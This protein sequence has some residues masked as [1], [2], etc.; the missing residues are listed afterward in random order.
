LEPEGRSVNEFYVQGMN[1]SMPEDVQAAIL[2][3][4]NGLENAR[5]I[6]TGYAIEYDYV[7]PTQ[8]KLTLECKGIS[9]LFTAGQINGTSGYEEAAAQGI[10]AGIN[11]ALYVKEK[12][13]FI[14]RRSEGFIGVLIDDLVTKGIDE[15]YRLLTSLAEYRLVLR[16]DNADLRL[17]EKG[18]LLGLVSE[19]RYKRLQTKRAEMSALTKKLHHTSVSQVDQAINRI[20][21]E[22]G[23][24]ELREATS[25]WQL[26]RRPEIGMEELV[27]AGYIDEG[28]DE[29]VLEQVEI[30][31]KYEGYIRK[32]NDQIKRFEALEDKKLSPELDYE[33]VTGLSSE[34]RYK[35]MRV[36][37]TSV[38]QASR[39]SGVSPADISVLLIHLEKLKRQGGNPDD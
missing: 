4:I 34:G 10:M 11:A 39:I 13:P 19:A 32:Q 26:L 37:P 33:S 35:L 29:E 20:L 27:S 6:R 23:S 18:Y 21:V 7:I 3:S 31:C 9:G 16:Q 5:I 15:P 2:H 38:G 25:L 17:T 24:R 14:L 36:K 1:T 22:K 28:I 30:E 12:E 8:L